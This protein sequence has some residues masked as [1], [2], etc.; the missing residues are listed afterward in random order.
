MREEVSLWLKQA[1][2]DL[3]T[4]EKLLSSGIFYASV[5]FSHQAAEKFVKACWIHLKG[6][7]P[8]KSHNLVGL[9]RELG[10]GGTLIDAAAELAPEYILTRYPTPEVAVPVDLY[11]EN[12]ARKHFDA[13][14]EII[15]WVKS[16]IK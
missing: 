10:G 6:E 5:F 9:I 11:T 8:P 13:A 2:A 14:L 12:S 1:D 16:N 15:S 4:A 7:L 3:S